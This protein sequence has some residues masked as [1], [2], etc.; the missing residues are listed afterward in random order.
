MLKDK[1]ALILNKD[2]TVSFLA[3]PNSITLSE[4]D[5]QAAIEDSFEP[6]VPIP[7]ALTP[8]KGSRVSVRGKITKVADF[9]LLIHPSSRFNTITQ[10]VSQPSK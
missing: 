8:K 5:K 7:E 4:D 1:T 2:T 9:C 3:I 10:K 6:I